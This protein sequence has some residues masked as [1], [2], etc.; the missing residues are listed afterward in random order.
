MLFIRVYQVTWTQRAQLVSVF[1]EFSQF[2]DWESCILE[3]CSVLGKPG[4]LCTLLGVKAVSLLPSRQPCQGGRAK[5]CENSFLW[6]NAICSNMDGPR[7]WHSDWS[8]REKEKY[9]T[10]TLTCGIRKKWYTWTC[11]QKKTHRL[12]EWAYGC[13]EKGTVRE[14]RRDMYTLL[15]LKWYHVHGLEESI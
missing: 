12:R 14:F 5:A 9:H 11:K 2:V 15:Y 6:N 1:L 4:W 10:T 3:S 7:E 13:R 8:E